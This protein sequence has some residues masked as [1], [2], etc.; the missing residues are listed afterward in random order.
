MRT[1]EVLASRILFWGGVA[2]I[3]LMALGIVGFAARG[4]LSD[5]GVPGATIGPLG[6][7]VGHPAIPAGPVYTSVAE[8]ARAWRQWPIDPL[9]LV[10]TGTLLLLVTPL[11]GVVAVFF[12]FIVG[13]ERRY[14]GI[15]AVLI[16]ALL[17]SLAFVSR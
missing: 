11:V 8:V 10:T 13:G 6:R 7:Q 1:A 15:A 17:V 9:A 5:S 16:A 2:S 12:V 3:L 4:G 14:A